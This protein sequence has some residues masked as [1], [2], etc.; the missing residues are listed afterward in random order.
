MTWNCTGGVQLSAKDENSQT[1]SATYNDP[2]FWRPNAVS[3][4]IPYTTNISYT[5]ATS[6]ETSLKFNGNISTADTLITLDSL[7]RVHI[8]QVKESQS[9]TIY[10]GR[11]TD[12]NVA[13]CRLD[14]RFHILPRQVRRQHLLIRE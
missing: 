3:D 2:Y 11:E 12:Y 13:G 6:A 14:Q 9:S 1:V 8:A 4:Q 10:D 5:G 7:G